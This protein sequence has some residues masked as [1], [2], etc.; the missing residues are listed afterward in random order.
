MPVGTYS[1]QHFSLHPDGTRLAFQHNT[2]IIEQDWE[3][4]NLLPFIQSGRTHESPL[5]SR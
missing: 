4:A 5:G 2:G 1:P 3:I